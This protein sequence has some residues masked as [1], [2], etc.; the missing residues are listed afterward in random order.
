MGRI[1]GGLA[2]E[3]L[4][5]SDVTPFVGDM[6][7]G[8]GVLSAVRHAAVLSRTP[9]VWS[10]PAMPLGSHPPVWPSPS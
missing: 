8:F 9:A 10:R 4:K 7:S 6:P 1:A 2:T 3:D 5:G